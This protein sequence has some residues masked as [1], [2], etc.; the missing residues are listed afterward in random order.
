MYTAVAPAESGAKT[1]TTVVPFISAS[2]APPGPYR[3]SVDVPDSR[4]FDATVQS[5]GSERRA[6]AERGQVRVRIPGVGV[7][8]V[9]GQV[10]V[11]IV[12]WRSARAAWRS[13]SWN[14]YRS[15]ESSS[16]CPDPV[17]EI[18]PKAS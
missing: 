17:F 13:G 7:E 18:L 10:A 4:L 9:V 14:S 16:P 11:S 15:A 6:A 3:I 1:L 5:V 2:F 8:A 12:G